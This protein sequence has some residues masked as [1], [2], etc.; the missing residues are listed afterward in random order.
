[1]M[2]GAIPGNPTELTTQGSGYMVATAEACGMPQATIQRAMPNIL[3]GVMPSRRWE[4]VLAESRRVRTGAPPTTEQ[5]TEI[6]KL[7]GEFTVR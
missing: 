6:E 7:I 2:R 4:D 1:M 3:R 5:C